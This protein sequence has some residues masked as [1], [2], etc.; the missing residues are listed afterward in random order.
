MRKARRT[1]KYLVDAKGYEVKT[2]D[3]R[4]YLIGSECSTEGCDRPVLSKGLCTRCYQRQRNGKPL[5]PRDP[6]DEARA[7][8]QRHALR[9]FLR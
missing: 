2:R 6:E 5:T 4:G 1:G 7:R 3:S 8:R 9:H